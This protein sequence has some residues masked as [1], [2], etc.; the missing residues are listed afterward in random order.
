MA[1]RRPSR[2]ILPRAFAHL[3][4]S[5]QHRL[6]APEIIYGAGKTVPQISAII[7]RLRSVR[8]SVLATRIDPAKARQLC[9]LFPKGKYHS[10]ART[11][12]L[13]SPQRVN[14]SQPSLS[15]AICA[16]GTSDHPVAEEAYVTLE[17]LGHRPARF[18]DIGVAGLHRT[19]GHIHSLRNY[20]ALIVVAGMEAALPS[21][22]GGLIRSPLIAVPT[23]VG[24]GAHLKGI[25]AL[26]GMLNSCA[27]G[28][29]VVNID[30]GFGAAYSVHRIALTSKTTTH[31]R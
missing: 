10:P 17:F 31:R 19:L 2:S 22:L 8:Q 30:N 1:R 13:L 12:T 3:D 6:G 16:A 25:T 21:V 9:R 20:H 29:T 11:F 15:V 27:P 4:L 18:Y 14:F 26:L 23:S 7:R 5:R 28:I 24:Y